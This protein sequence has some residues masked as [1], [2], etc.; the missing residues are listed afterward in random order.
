MIFTCKRQSKYTYVQCTITN[1]AANISE[2]HSIFT[3][4]M[5]FNFL[6][7]IDV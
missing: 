6:V 1:M 4:G 2:S 5:K 3:I 7:F